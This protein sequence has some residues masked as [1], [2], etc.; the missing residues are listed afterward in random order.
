ML[1]DQNH[2]N[3]LWSAWIASPGAERFGQ[4]VLNRTEEPRLKEH[5]YARDNHAVW[6]SMLEYLY[7]RD[8]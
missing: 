3:E 2:L 6:C 7:L 8:G 4:Y 1:R 5:F